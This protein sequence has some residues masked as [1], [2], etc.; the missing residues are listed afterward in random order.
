MG[1]L[2][3][4]SRV[5]MDERN[6]RVVEL[7]FELAVLNALGQVT[8]PGFPEREAVEAEFAPLLGAVF[9][10]IKELEVDPLIPVAF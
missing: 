6:Y 10:L 4:R 9:A 7:L 1:M 2:C 8:Q 3:N 5:S